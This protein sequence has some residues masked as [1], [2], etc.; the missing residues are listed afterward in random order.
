M[1][2]RGRCL[3]RQHAHVGVVDA[4]MGPVA[5]DRGIGELIVDPRVLAEWDPVGGARGVVEQPAQQRERQV[6]FGGSEIARMRNGCGRRRP[7]TMPG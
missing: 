2:L 4:E 6:F 7:L 3:Q 5:L 1:R